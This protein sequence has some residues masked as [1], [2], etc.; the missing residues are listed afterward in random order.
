MPILMD[1]NDPEMGSQQR[2][3]FAEIMDS[4]IE[5]G[6]RARFAR[7]PPS[8]D[9][10]TPCAP[11]G[12]LGVRMG[13]CAHLRRGGASEGRAE[14]AYTL[15]HRASTAVALLLGA[16]REARSSACGNVDC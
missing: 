9:G 15:R 5:L 3:F 16:R 13:Y 1:A 11:R 10:C 14:R 2:R 4:S 6:G 7:R 8:V 12:E